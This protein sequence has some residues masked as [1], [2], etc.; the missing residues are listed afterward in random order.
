VIGL[1]VFVLHFDSCSR[2]FPSMCKRPALASIYWVAGAHLRYSSWFMELTIPLIFSCHAW[3]TFKCMQQIIKYLCQCVSNI[4]AL[5][6]NFHYPSIYISDTAMSWDHC[7]FLYFTTQLKDRIK[8]TLKY[9]QMLL[10]PYDNTIH[11]TLPECLF[12][13]LI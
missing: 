1:R 3:A 4:E 12:S 5:L 2:D 6:T 13:L 9:D 7:L 10:I 8:Q 11:R